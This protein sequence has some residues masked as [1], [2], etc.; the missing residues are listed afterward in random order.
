MKYSNTL[1]FYYSFLSSSWN[2]KVTCFEEVQRAMIVQV[3]VDLCNMILSLYRIRQRAKKFYFHFVY[4]LLGISVTNGWLLYHRDQTQK[5][6]PEKSQLSM[7]EFQTAIANDLRSAAKLALASRL[8]WGRPSFTTTVKEP[9][10]KCRTP[11]FQI[12]LIMHVLINLIIFLYSKRS[13]NAAE[14]AEAGI[15]L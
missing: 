12:L 5:S 7:L 9:L 13:S 4:Y 6:I 3:F 1:V 10:K 14:N 2:K 15:L 8:S 11:K